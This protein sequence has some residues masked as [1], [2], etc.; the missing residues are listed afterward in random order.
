[1]IRNEYFKV[2]DYE[3]PY[4]DPEYNNYIDHMYILGIDIAVG[5]IKEIKFASG[6]K[7]IIMK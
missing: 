7:I 5:I 2:I 6:G 4:H 3:K 1:M